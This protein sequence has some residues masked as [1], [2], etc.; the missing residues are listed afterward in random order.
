MQY[1]TKTGVKIFLPLLQTAIFPNTKTVY[2]QTIAFINRAVSHERYINKPPNL[3]YRFLLTYFG[4]VLSY[5]PI[6]ILTLD[7]SVFVFVFVFVI[8]Y[9]LLEILATF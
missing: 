5:H 9:C 3:Q 1:H 6:L 2:I 7:S 8:G 4:F